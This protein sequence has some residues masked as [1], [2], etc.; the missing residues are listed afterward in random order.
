MKCDCSECVIRGL[1]FSNAEV[2]EIE[3]ICLIKKERKFNKGDLIYQTGDP[4]N[5]LVYLKSGL[6]KYYSVFKD[7]KSHILSIA[8]PFDAISLLNTFNKGFSL[9]NLSA[10]E[11]SVLCYIPLKE[12]Q[13]IIKKNGEFAFDFIQKFSNVS[14]N[15]I[16]QLMLINSKNLSGR[17]AFILLWF[18][19][20]I[21]NKNVYEIPISRKEIAELIGMTT[22]NVIRALSEFR[23]EKIIRI[24]GKEVEII[25][26]ER[27]TKISIYG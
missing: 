17:V 19:Q 15:T 22:E 16:H 6:V 18:A 11:N 8:K 25:D 23:Q 14:K 27:L 13:S 7:G 9:Y 10:L 3:S 26:L 12:I 24:N 2:E 1:M 5:D 4:M 21:Y 20:N